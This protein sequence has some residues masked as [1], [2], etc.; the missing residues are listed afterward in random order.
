MKRPAL[1]LLLIVLLI[2][3]AGVAVWRGSAGAVGPA[4]VTAAGGAE[5]NRTAGPVGSPS[6]AALPS[7]L[8]RPVPAGLSPAEKAARVDQIKRDYE[9]VRTKASADYAAAGAAFPGGLNAFLRQLA[10][11]EREKHADLAA[12][13]TERE[14]EDLEM[15]DTTAGQLVQKLLGDTAATD[16]QR[17]AAFRIQRAFDDQF[18]LTFDLSP[19]TL[20]KREA[21]RQ[22]TQRGINVVL[23]SD[24]LFTAWMRGEGPDYANFRAFAAQQ[25][26][27][28]DTANQLWRVKDDY[29]IRRLD[30]SVQPGLSPEQLQAAQAAVTEATRARVLGILGPAAFQ[31]DGNDVLGWLPKPK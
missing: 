22:G 14:L 20:L 27:P 30:V 25:G 15:R 6:E 24:D 11:L 19:A 23:G 26:L 3:G 28:T 10:L 8:P 9:E 7:R 17:R 13:L 21:A 29:T 1:A 31:A 4:A 18:A 12:I 2:T 5:N 16:E